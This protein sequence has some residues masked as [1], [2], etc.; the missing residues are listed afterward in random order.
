MD[1]Q[2]TIDNYR[3]DLDLEYKVVY[4]C[5]STLPVSRVLDADLCVI[6]LPI[7][8]YPTQLW[9]YRT[10]TVAFG[11]TT[12]VLVATGCVEKNRHS[13]ALVDVDGRRQAKGTVVRFPP[14]STA[15]SLRGKDHSNFYAQLIARSQAVYDTQL[16]PDPMQYFVYVDSPVGRMPMLAFAVLATE[17]ALPS[18]A[19]AFFERLYSLAVMHEPEDDIELLN[20]IFTLPL[21]ALLYQPDQERVT[22]T[23]TED[24]DQWT[25]LSCFPDLALAAFDC[26]DGSEFVLELMSVFQRLEFRS[27]RL[28]QLQLLFNRYQPCMAIG[29]LR[30]SSSTDCVPHA[31]VV[32]LDNAFFDE[33]RKESLRPAWVVESTN[34]AAATWTRPSSSSALARYKASEQLLARIRGSETRNRALLKTKT[35]MT[36]AKEQHMY[37]SL[38]AL[39][40]VFRNGDA[41]HLV[42]KTTR[43]GKGVG[44]ELDQLLT[45]QA[46]ES[47]CVLEL[48]GEELQAMKESFRQ[49][50]RAEFPQAATEPIKTTTKQILCN[51]RQVDYELIQTDLPADL[52]VVHN[53]LT[54]QGLA[55]TCLCSASL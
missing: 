7:V 15:L 26:E 48:K 21:R 18:H 8:A 29:Q 25:R 36:L 5:D 27:P 9:L 14:L 1:L 3:A 51:L 40:V 17:I 34:Y 11:L 6:G 4:W 39:L 49:L 19:E 43:N 28:R 20:E 44:I 46:V 22:Q 32:C 47:V 13:F 2:F 30:S 23:E 38:T 37:R 16:R 50:P 10:A 35:P 53:R 52:T 54:H 41:K 31:F 24:S 33:E 55:L 42:M 12:Q 45:Y